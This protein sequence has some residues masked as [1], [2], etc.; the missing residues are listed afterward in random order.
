MLIVLFTKELARRLEK[1]HVTVN[2]V[3][4]GVVATDAFREYPKWVSNFLN[5]LISKPEVGANSVIYLATSADVQNIS[6]EYFNKSKATPTTDIAKDIK[7][8]K[9]IWQE[10]VS[11]LNKSSL[12]TQF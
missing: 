1:N 6:G 5:L 4:P 9:Q 7:L 12:K 8:A 11:L 10:T 2:C 3:H